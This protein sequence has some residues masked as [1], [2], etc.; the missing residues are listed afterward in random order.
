MFITKKIKYSFLAEKL[1]AF[2]KFKSFSNSVA[3]NAYVTESEKGG[4][5]LYSRKNFKKG[6]V[7]FIA[8][9][10]VRYGNFIGSECYLHPDWYGVDKNTWIAPTYPSIKINH[11]C[12]PNTGIFS[13]R[14]FVALR[15]I[16]K[17]DELTFDYSISDDEEV[18]I[19]GPG[20]PIDCMCGEDDCR[21]E[22]RSIQFLNQENFSN[23]L[24]LIPKYLQKVYENK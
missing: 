24:P 11:S 1:R 16:N 5:G 21:R 12:R 17:G 22:I 20:Y 3:K 8:R 7:V 13:A 9:G 2:S 6:A 23:L 19:M 10:P 14:C 18:W 15:D 4:E